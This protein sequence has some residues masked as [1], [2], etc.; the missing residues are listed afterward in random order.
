MYGVYV[1]S[2]IMPVAKVYKHLSVYGLCKHIKGVAP[3]WRWPL[4][5]PCFLRR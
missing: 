3:L 5:P 2:L 1:S 4:Q